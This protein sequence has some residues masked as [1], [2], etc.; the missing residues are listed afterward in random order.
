M[1][2]FLEVC[3]LLGIHANTGYQ[4]RKDGHFPIR[5]ERVGGRYACRGTDVD[6]YFDKAS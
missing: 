2:P 5:V 4:L 3:D 1:V 6:E